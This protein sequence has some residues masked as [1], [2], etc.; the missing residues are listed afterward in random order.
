MVKIRLRRTGAKKK[1]T[2]R[3]VVTDLRTPRDGRFIEIVGHY[4]PRTEPVT[5]NIQEDRVLHWLSVGAQ[6]SD[7]VR[8]LLENV[9]TLERFARLKAGADLDELLAEAKA[10]HEKNATEPQ[11]A[12]AKAEPK[13]EQTDTEETV[14]AEIESPEGE[15]ESSGKEASEDAETE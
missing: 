12:V 10:S 6:P 1:P 2:Y 4:N 9:G 5:F 15:E 11:A 8:G 13:V 14:A 3:V 7:T